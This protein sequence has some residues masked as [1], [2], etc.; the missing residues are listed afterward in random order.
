[1]AAASLGPGA[2]KRWILAQTHKY[3]FWLLT[4][5]PVPWIGESAWCAS[6]LK[7]IYTGS[8]K[9]FYVQ[10]SFPVYQLHPLWILKLTVYS[11][12]LCG[13]FG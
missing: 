6:S 8:T 5:L 4:P 9:V 13:K 11:T 12:T 10:S 7:T 3:S 1:M 2:E